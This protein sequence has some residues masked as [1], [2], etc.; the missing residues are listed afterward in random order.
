MQD[1]ESCSSKQLGRRYIYS[2]CLFAGP[3][4]PG[5][6]ALV[7]EW[8]FAIQVESLKAIAFTTADGLSIK[9]RDIA[10]GGAVMLLRSKEWTVPILS[11]TH[12]HG[13]KSRVIFPVMVFASSFVL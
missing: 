5:Y 12:R 4:Q 8:V 1:T 7:L 11:E 10:S 13:R 6:F 3:A 9:L 2:V